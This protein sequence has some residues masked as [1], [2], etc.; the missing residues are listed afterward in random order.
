[1]GVIGTEGT[2]NSRS[3]E[4]TLKEIRPNLEV[5]SLACPTLVSL[6]EKEIIILVNR[7]SIL[8]NSL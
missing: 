2:I 1:M 4:T 3:Y 6:V 8:L 5:N 7:L